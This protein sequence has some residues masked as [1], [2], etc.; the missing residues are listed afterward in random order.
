MPSK[1]KPRIRTVNLF[2]EQGE[3]FL[4]QKQYILICCGVQSGKTFTGAV[5]ARNKMQAFGEFNGLISAPTYKILQQSTMDKLFSLFPE[6]RRFYK[7]QK[8]V[9]ELPTGGHVFIRSAD[10]P[11]GIEGMTIHW[12]WL[13]EYGQSPRLAWT[14]CRSRVSITRGQLMITTTPYALNWLYEDVYEPWLKHEDIDIGFFTWPSIRNPYFDKDH[15][16]KEKKRLSPEEF[17]RRYVGEFTRMEGLVYGDFTSD[18]IVEP[19]VVKPIYTFA[20]FDFGYTAPAAILVIQKDKDGHYWVVDE[21]YKTGKT[22]EELNK[23]CLF[24]QAKYKVERW[25]PDIAEP[26]RIASMRKIGLFCVEEKKDLIAGM[27]KVRALFR[28]KRLHIFKNCRN[29]IDEL[30][31]YHFKEGKEE[32]PEKTKDHA[33]DALRYAIV[34]EKG[35]LKAETMG[36]KVAKKKAQDP[37]RFGVDLEKIIKENLKFQ[38]M[39]TD[40]WKYS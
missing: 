5:W 27:D 29:L 36:T 33:C 10:Q 12:G 6:L 14:V 24:Y 38:G 31:V 8:Q 17:Q 13:D 18:L 35:I 30:Q 4:C 23:E 26:D 7:E 1:K 25:Y 34:S 21:F 40:A 32:E 20:G 11:L 22:Q 9:I 37:M 16:R 3:A 15:Y 2:E 28:Q 19:Q 39:G